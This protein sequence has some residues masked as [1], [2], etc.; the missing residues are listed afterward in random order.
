MSVNPGFGGQQFIPTSLPKLA[1]V[2]ARIAAS[3]RE[4]RLE[5]DGGIKVEN[6]AADRPRPAPTPSWR[7]RRSSAARDYAATIS[8]M[9]RQIAARQDR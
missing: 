9:R 2:R 4:V 8:A 6:I 5:V 7:A 3:G 1:D